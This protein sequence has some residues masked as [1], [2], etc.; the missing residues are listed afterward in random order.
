MADW[1]F[2]SVQDV[3]DRALNTRPD[4]E[5]N[6]A[7]QSF[8][9]QRAS[10]IRAALVDRG[11]TPTEV[12]QYDYPETWALLK[13]ANAYGALVDFRTRLS[14]SSGGASTVRQI[15]EMY[16]AMLTRLRDGS[17]PGLIDDEARRSMSPS[18]YATNNSSDATIAPRVT[19]GTRF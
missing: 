15:Q 14:G 16:D 17:I 11:L 5:D 2:A 18:S 3:F 8:L 4:A 10:E 7:V 9:V 6:E 12:W 1:T 13:L 19:R